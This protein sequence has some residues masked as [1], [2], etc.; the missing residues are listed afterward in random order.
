MST[1]GYNYPDYARI[2]D[3]NPE[4]R[5]IDEKSTKDVLNGLNQASEKKSK[6][7]SKNSK[8]FS[9]DKI[10]PKI[11][12]KELSI[13]VTFDEY[14]TYLNEIWNFI[15]KKDMFNLDELKD[16]LKNNKI[17]NIFGRN[18]G[19]IKNDMIIRI[20]I[21]ILAV[22]NIDNI[23]K[24]KIEGD[25]L[26]NIE[27]LELLDED[28][29]K[30]LL[31][32]A[33]EY[34]KIIKSNSN[35]DFS[36]SKLVPFNIAVLPPGD[37]T[38]IE[39]KKI[40]NAE[41]A[42]MGSFAVL[43][44]S[45][46]IPMFLLKFIVYIFEQAVSLFMTYKKYVPQAYIRTINFVAIMLKGALNK[47]E[48]QKCVR[49]TGLLDKGK[50]KLTF[51]DDNR[52]N[53]DE[54]NT[55]FPGIRNFLS[56]QRCKSLAN[57]RNK[58][59]LKYNKKCMP[60]ASSK[61]STKS[62]S[63]SSSKAS[64]K[65]SSKSSTK[66][67]SKSSSK[68]SKGGRRTRKKYAGARQPNP[69]VMGLLGLGFYSGL[70]ASWTAIFASAFSDPQHPNYAVAAVFW[71]IT[72]ILGSITGCCAAIG[73]LDFGSSWIKRQIEYW[74]DRRVN[75][76]Y[77]SLRGSNVVR[78]D[79]NLGVVDVDHINLNGVDAPSHNNLN[80]GHGNNDPNDDPNIDPMDYPNQLGFESNQIRNEDEDEDENNN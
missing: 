32:Q 62:S 75:N 16:R 36:N 42:N 52:V 37:W 48:Q 41:R 65:S 73:V 58:L 38:S 43:F 9:P 79:I 60:K 46:F 14:K 23:I 22:N 33:D 24:T 49:I 34:L 69:L 21:A 6:S 27:K 25:M 45:Y 10:N 47:R 35:G 8:V 66:L 12:Y 74:R 30:K 39:Y 57:T 50:Y 15:N 28:S 51:D 76:I 59:S 20:I 70:C 29:K 7:K 54:C 44:T 1:F 18:N 17:A 56:R 80:D 72:N 68:S 2:I 53:A 19:E 40:L 63:K 61:S 64:T 4:L 78:D 13:T 71:F 3:E 11:I 5:K 31:E 26:F 67:S 55:K 77:Q